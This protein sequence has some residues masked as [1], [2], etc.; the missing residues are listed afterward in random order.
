MEKKKKAVAPK[1]GAATQEETKQ[2]QMDVIKG[3]RLNKRAEL[4]MMRRK[5]SN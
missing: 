5:V 1:L 2:R 4:L 3:V